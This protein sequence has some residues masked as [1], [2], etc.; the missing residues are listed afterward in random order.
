MD[1]FRSNFPFH[2]GRNQHECRPLPY[3]S[4]ECGWS[5]GGCVVPSMP[6][7]RTDYPSTIG[8]G[9]CDIADENGPQSSTYSN[10]YPYSN[11]D[12]ECAG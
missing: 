8:D 11:H 5:A 6:D 3:N 4:K 12:D 2:S 7:C 9:I 1:F 10:G